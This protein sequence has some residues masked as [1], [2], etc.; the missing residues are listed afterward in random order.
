VVAH[1]KAQALLELDVLRDAYLG[2]GTQRTREGTGG[3]A[4]RYM[5]A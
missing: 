1:G 5:H 2:G 4:R 3:A